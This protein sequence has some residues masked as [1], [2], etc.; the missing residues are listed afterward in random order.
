MEPLNLLA[1]VLL[2][3]GDFFQVEVAIFNESIM[4]CCLIAGMLSLSILVA[5]FFTTKPDFGKG[6][7]TEE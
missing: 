7:E 6:P 5:A 3:L 2:L 1:T 4:L